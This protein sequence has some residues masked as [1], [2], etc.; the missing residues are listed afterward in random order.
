MPEK[1]MWTAK[2]WPQVFKRAM[3]TILAASCAVTAA[4][5]PAFAE[6]DINTLKD[7]QAQ[8]AQLQQQNNEKLAALRSDE[9]KKAEYGATLQSQVAAIEEQINDCSNQVTDLNLQMQQAEN[10]ISEKQKQ[11]DADYAKLKER[12]RALYMAGEARNLQILLSS[13]NLAD[14]SD[15]SEALQMVT[16]HD[17]TLINR[18]KADK[19]AV[20]KAKESI[21]QSREQAESVKTSFAQKQQELATALA[22]TNQFLKEIGQQEV[23]LQD[24]NASLDVQAAKIAASIDAWAQQ[25]EEKKKQQ[26]AAAAAESAASQQQAATSSSQSGSDSGQSSNSGSGS[27][28][29]SSSS[30][31]TS[32]GSFS[33]LIAEAEKHLGKPYVMGASGP[34]TFDCS[35]FVCWVFTHSGVYNLPRTT[36]QGIYNQCT[37]VSVSE[38]RPG[39]IVFFTDTYDCGETVTHVGIYTGSNTMIHAGNPVQYT[40]IDTSYW[41]KHFYAFGRL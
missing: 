33:S 27:A 28:S 15:K 23:N 22:E 26:E 7:K 36:A 38:A 21:Q 24:K 12:L 4:V 8:Y 40:S 37:P 14:L 29:N 11:I 34:D 10:E 6:D 3:I 19:A 9:S 1:E 13:D 20:Q 30:P 35:S 18:L 17:T 16:E 2:C 5:G 32:S 25:Q 39:D 31:S 41:R